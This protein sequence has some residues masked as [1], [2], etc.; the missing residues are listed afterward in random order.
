MAWQTF[1]VPKRT[2]TYSDVLEAYGL[3]SLV[4]ALIYHATHGQAT[5]RITI[6]DVGSYYRV[7]STEPVREEWPERVGY[8]QP[9][10]KYI[11]RTKGESAPE[12]LNSGDVAAM[13]ERVQQYG[14]QRRALQAEGLRGSEIE[15][16][17]MD[18]KPPPDWAVI[19]FIGDG[20]MQA[21]GIYNRILAQWP[22]M[23]PM[24]AETVRCLL[25]RYAALNGEADGRC[26][27]WE[28]DAKRQGVKVRETASQLL[29]PH[30]GKG[31]NEPKA[32]ALRM[33]NVKD[34]PWP[35]EFLKVLGLW[36]CMAPR[37]VMDPQRDWKVYVLAPLRLSLVDHKRAFERFNQYLWQERGQATSLKADITSLLLFVKAWLDYTEAR[38]RR[39]GQDRVGEDAVPE[40]VVAGFHVAQFK[41]LSQQ[42]YTMV[43]LSFLQLPAWSG[44]L[45][46]RSDVAALKRVIDEHLDVIHAV[47]E[48]HSD[49]YDMLKDYR[50][51]VAGG[52]WEGFFA[53][54]TAYAHY[55]MQRMI[56][57][58][59]LYT[60]LFT[61]PNLRRLLMTEKKFAPILESEGF[62][63]FAYAIRH[64][65][66]IPQSRKARG[67][68]TLYDIR[69]GL[70]EEL[71]R[72]ATVKEEFIAALMNFA[73][74]YNRENAQIL[75]RT[76]QQMRRDLRTSDIDDVVRLVD[77]YGSE[78]VA[79]LLVAYGYAREP[80]EEEGE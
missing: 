56:Q 68:N 6:E 23:R 11:L 64:S 69:Y 31:L 37:Q 22:K 79:H 5:W 80:R 32:H 8:F 24:L 3:A 19:V 38:Y 27:A 25:E 41:K 75:D 33:D 46:T 15:Q 43:N 61:T 71:K 14:E 63:N 59:N 4:N 42:A 44:D 28:R 73:Q 55:A 40:K 2:G 65:T 47:D 54:T 74:S 20:R 26:A 76:K 16:M 17:L 18:Q 45:R 1:Y 72:K 12:G 21:V 9:P 34:R 51:F 62:R 35:E 77:E 10:A 49:G 53:F 78:V 13:W 52:K 39:E 60:P 48:N 66:V 57:Q 58:P 70:G 36:Q 29:N 67:L 30:Q 50:D 7:H